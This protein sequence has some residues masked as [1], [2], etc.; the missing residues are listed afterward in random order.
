[1]NIEGNTRL[2]ALRELRVETVKVDVSS[3]KPLMRIFYTV[4]NATHSGQSVL[5]ELTYLCL[6]APAFIH[7]SLFQQLLRP[8]FV[9]IT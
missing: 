7:Q 2:G 4:I 9:V 8:M 5:S 1:M 6:F 3:G